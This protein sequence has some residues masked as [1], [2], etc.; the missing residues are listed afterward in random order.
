MA[1]LAI[2]L[3][4]DW[5]IGDP[6]WL[7]RRVNHPVV[8]FGAVIDW[9]D[10]KLVAC[11]RKT[12]AVRANSTS[13]WWGFALI[14]TLFTFAM[15]VSA[16]VYGVFSTAWLL[17]TIFEVLIIV[18]FLAQ[19]S[20]RDHVRRVADALHDD[21]LDDGRREVAMIVGRDVSQLDE[22]GVSKAAI[23][24]LAENLS[25]GIVAPAFWYA[26]G[27]LPGIIFYKAVNTAD[28]M[29]GHRSKRYEY[30]GKPAAIL[31]DLMNWIPARLSL[32]L[33]MGATA[34]TRGLKNAW[35]V[36]TVACNDAPKHRSPNAGWPEAGFA[37]ALGLQLGGPRNYGDDVIDGVT[38]NAAGRDTTGP[39][40]IGRA[41]GLFRWICLLLLAIIGLFVI[42]PG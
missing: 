35:L 18:A 9:F 41:L 42:I 31:D 28:S 13:V 11:F 2:A 4:I 32:L 6:D 15:A 26:I 14:L 19:K 37:A 17:G 24:S 23:E 12:A 10:R 3:I 29:I 7:W 33:V 39:E 38:L 25:D 16:F 34:L 40:D 8:W 5:W 1:L 21:G 30:F 36:W 22:S 27:G 20:L